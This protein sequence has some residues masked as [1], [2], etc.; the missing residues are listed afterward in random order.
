MQTKHK[1]IS[2]Y[3]CDMIN[4]TRQFSRLGIIYLTFTNDYPLYE[5]WL[6]NYVQITKNRFGPRLIEINFSMYYFFRIGNWLT[7]RDHKITHQI[8][9]NQTKTTKQSKASTDVD[10]TNSNKAS[11]DDV[12]A[13]K[14]YCN[15]G[16]P[17]NQTGNRYMRETSTCRT[18]M[19]RDAPRVNNLRECL[20]PVKNYYLRQH[21]GP[22]S[23]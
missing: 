12:H 14:A 23:L 13:N 6:S 3:H 17:Q 21:E 11:T 15:V 5:Q 10:L 1:C 8:R 7:F 4:I 9:P 16:K 20:L 19:T 22:S 18:S 2:F